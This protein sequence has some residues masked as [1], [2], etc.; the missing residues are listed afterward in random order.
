MPRAK[1]EEAIE[2]EPTV[3]VDPEN[4]NA[5]PDPQATIPPEPATEPMDPV[6]H[7]RQE[8]QHWTRIPEYRWKD[9]EGRIYQ[10]DTKGS[11][12]FELRIVG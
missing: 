7:S 1:K 2:N 8:P 3:T 9:A 10:L 5:T 12:L 4:V 6:E 11:G